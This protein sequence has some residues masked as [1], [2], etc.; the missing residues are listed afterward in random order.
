MTFPRE[1]LTEL[2]SEGQIRSYPEE[3]FR[4]AAV[5]AVDRQSVDAI[6]TRLLA[7]EHPL[8]IT[9]YSGRNPAAVA[10]LDELA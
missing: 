7:A 4:A 8:L 5:G 6:A 9:A 3:R 2:W 10:L 1:T